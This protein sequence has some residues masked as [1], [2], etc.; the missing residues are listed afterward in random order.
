MR[1]KIL[2]VLVAVIVAT[3]TFTGVPLTSHA[4]SGVQRASTLSESNLPPAYQ[5]FLT[6]VGGS[7]FVAVDDVKMHYVENGS[8]QQPTL[9]LLHGS[10]DNIFTWRSIMPI[11]TQHYHVIAPDL[12]GFG[13]SDH[14]AIAY[15]WDVEIHYLTGFIQALHLHHV[16]LVVTDIG[17]LFGFAYATNHPENVAGIA[18][19]ETVTAPIPSYDVLGS[20]CQACVGFFQGPKNP[21]LANQYI[22]NN[23][24]F[25][26]QIYAGSGLLH[27]LSASDLAGYAFFLATPAE[28]RIVAEIGAQMPIAGDQ[29]SNFSTITAFARYLRTSEVP[30]LV[31]YAKPGSI[32]PGATAIGLGMPNTRYASVGAGY[33]YLAEDEPV[34]IANAVL[35]WRATFD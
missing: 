33:H 3:I 17:G 14:P 26:A 31:L 6:S 25:A 2:W 28:R 27:P 18:L 20:Y 5:Q 30:K 8:T 9:L 21:T 13:L 1:R 7:H 16:T 15:T 32:L 10:P 4:A 24:Q 22:I 23:P 35:A 19:W 12:V 11:L 29:A 34:A